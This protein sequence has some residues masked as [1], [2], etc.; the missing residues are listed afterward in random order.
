[1]TLNSVTLSVSSNR[2]FFSY[3]ASRDERY[4]C[5][6]EN[7]LRI[8]QIRDISRQKL[9]TDVLRNDLNDTNDPTLQLYIEYSAHELTRQPSV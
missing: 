9:S 7:T 2:L 6:A 1:M 3:T 4:Y 5:L 8:C